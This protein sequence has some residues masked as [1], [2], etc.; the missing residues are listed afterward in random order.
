MILKKHSI[1]IKQYSKNVLILNNAAWLS[2]EHGSLDDALTYSKAAFELAPKVVNVV[3]TYGMI[4]LKHNKKGEA[5]SHMAKAYE[6]S[7]GKIPDVTLNYAEVLIA[8]KR[9][10]KAEQV[11]NSVRNESTIQK[12]RK[13]KL[14]K[15]L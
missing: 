3:D 4:L 2:I 10:K 5:L 8:N 7:E 14:K 11:L 1:L 6:L 9:M 15:L 12:E 13:I